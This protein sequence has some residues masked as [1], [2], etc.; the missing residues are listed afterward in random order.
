[1]FFHT[2]LFYARNNYCS[3][4]TVLLLVPKIEIINSTIAPA[5]IQKKEIFM[6]CIKA[7]SP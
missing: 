3:E 6:P 1:M 4:F 7:F 2:S 5:A